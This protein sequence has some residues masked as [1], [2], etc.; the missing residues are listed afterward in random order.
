VP[1][2][3]ILSVVERLSHIEG[4]YILNY[5]L[6]LNPTIFLEMLGGGRIVSQIDMGLIKL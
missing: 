2:L 4:G 5:F 3:L 1:S 6:P